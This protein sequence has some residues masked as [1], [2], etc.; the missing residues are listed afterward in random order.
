MLAGVNSKLTVPDKHSGSQPSGEDVVDAPTRARLPG[1][2]VVVAAAAVGSHRCAVVEV[3]VVVVVVDVVDV[4]LVLEV[5]LVVVVV[6][7]VLVV[8]VVVE[9]VLV[10]LVVVVVDVVVVVV[11][12]HS[13]DQLDSPANWKLRPHVSWVHASSSRNFTDDWSTYP[14]WTERWCWS[15]GKVAGVGSCAWVPVQSHV[16]ANGPGADAAQ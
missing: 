9:V 4:E 2:G 8:E 10:V 6:L 16:C 1:P 14:N 15:S 13:A 5:V 3:V 11:V 7:V 12:R